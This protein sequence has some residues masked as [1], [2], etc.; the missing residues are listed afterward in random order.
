M[1]YTWLSRESFLDQC[2]ELDSLFLV[3]RDLLLQVVD[4]KVVIPVGWGQIRQ[5]QLLW[6]LNLCAVLN[7][8]QKELF[9]QLNKLEFQFD[10]KNPVNGLNRHKNRDLSKELLFNCTGIFKFRL[11]LRALLVD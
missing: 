1:E 5:S 4:E 2:F 6:D 8:I 7:V 3:G 10:I 9:R 11:L